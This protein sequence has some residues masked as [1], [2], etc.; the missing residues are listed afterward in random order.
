M[1]WALVFFSQNR[2]HIQPIY[3]KNTLICIC[4]CLYL[5]YIQREWNWDIFKNWILCTLLRV[6]VSGKHIQKHHSKSSN[7]KWIFIRLF[8]IS[9]LCSHT[10]RYVFSTKFIV[11]SSLNRLN[12]ICQSKY[13]LEFIRIHLCFYILAQNICSFLYIFLHPAWPQKICLLHSYRMPFWIL[14]SPSYKYLS[15]HCT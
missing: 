11:I 6:W 1:A 10:H 9:V 7:C 5:P 8:V 14:F 3:A 4:T 15:I 13:L 2:F 12:A